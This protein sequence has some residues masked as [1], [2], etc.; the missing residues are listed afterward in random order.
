MWGAGADYS[1]QTRCRGV[2]CIM[3]VQRR[4]RNCLCVRLDKFASNSK[5]AKI[6]IYN[7]REECERNII[8][9]V[10]EAWMHTLK[11]ISMD[12]F[13]IL[14]SYARNYSA[15]RLP[16]DDTNELSPHSSPNEF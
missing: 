7:S 13:V 12:E 3:E 2:L 1:H 14:A 6:A 8:I 9:F 11:N 4:R 10:I 5:P 16:R 15:F